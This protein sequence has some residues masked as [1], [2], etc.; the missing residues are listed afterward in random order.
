M[1]TSDSW[2]P[3]PGQLL[4]SLPSPALPQGLK[5]QAGLTNGTTERSGRPPTSAWPT[6]MD[7]AAAHGLASGARVPGGPLRPAVSLHVVW[8]VSPPPPRIQ[9]LLP[10]QGQLLMQGMGRRGGRSSRGRPEAELA[11][12]YPPAPER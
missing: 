2:G 8:P 4:H 6:K 10:E 5:E 11:G 3:G 1:G 7:G 9:A 12:S